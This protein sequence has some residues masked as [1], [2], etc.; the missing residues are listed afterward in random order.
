MPAAGRFEAKVLFI[1]LSYTDCG[2]GLI[3]VCFF[4]ITVYRANV[5]DCT[6]LFSYVVMLRDETD[7][8]GCNFI[9]IVIT[10]RAHMIFL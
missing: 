4:P 9:Q 5:F 3:F 10:E 8:I 6:G 7:L 2:W 1:A